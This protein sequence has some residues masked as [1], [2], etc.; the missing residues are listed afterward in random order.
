MPLTEEQVKA[1]KAQLLSQIE[2]LPEDKKAEAEREIESLSPEA[3]ESMLKQQSSGKSQKEKSVFRMI[4]SK[5]IPSYLIDENPYAN[6]VLE[7]NPVSKGHSIIIPKLPAKT[8]KEIPTKAFALAK[9][10]SKKII[11]KLEAK[12]AEIQTET[13]FGEAIIN[14]IPVYDE[15]LSINSPRQKASKEELEALESRLKKIKR[16]PKPKIKKEE[17]EPP[18]EKPEIIR[19]P[20]KIP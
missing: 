17:K 13:K 15:P 14:V 2:N 20:R 6:A 4:I 3:L 19:L 7:I 10:I 1:L 11:S 8:S 16:N 5:E 18:K 9:K 12:S